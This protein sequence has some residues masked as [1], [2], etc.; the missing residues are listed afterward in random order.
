MNAARS[1]KMQQLQQP[2]DVI[3][4][5]GGITGAAIALEC[6]RGGLKTLLLEQRD[7]AWGTSSRSSKLVHGGLRYL[8]E[9]QFH[10][11]AESVKEREALKQE[12]RGLIDPQSF[13]L[14]HYPRRKPGRL[15]FKLGLTL[16]DAIAGKRAHRYINTSSAPFLAPHID[17]RQLQGGMQYWD[18]KTDDARLVM[19]V[20]EEAE[21]A[22]ALAIN[23]CC[24]ENLLK[25]GD[26]V[27]GIE[28][29][30]VE[31]DQRT[32]IRASVVVNATGAWVDQLRGQIG[33][34]QKIRPLRGSH[35]LFPLWKVPV[36]QS[37]SFFHPYDDRPVFIYP[38]EG[39]ALLGTTDVDHPDELNQEAV[40][41]PEE[42]AYLLAALHYQFPGLNIALSD[43]ISSYA[44]V[45]PVIGTGQIDPS[46]E[47]RDHLILNE[48]GLITV[49]GGKLTTFRP[50]AL[51]T[52][53]I[54]F[55]ALGKPQTPRWSPVFKTAEIT[56]WPFALPE[57]TRQRLSGR[58]GRVLESALRTA[59]RADFERIGGTDTL[60]LE[61]RMAAEDKSVVHLDDL[62][63]RR[64]R[65]GNVLKEG[66]KELLPVIQRYVQ[67]QLGWTSE[68]W[69]A[70]AQRYVAL[71][72]RNYSVPARIPP[73]E[74][75][76]HPKAK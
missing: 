76:L 69:Q 43:V 12:A 25:A 45:R 9:G 14:A 54:I 35:L 29:R 21:A 57:S 34:E 33:G 30:D 59:T 63:L 70:E 49:T 52:V 13:F 64:T 15:T 3:I 68:Q 27:V 7:F 39:V 65:L 31:T 44:G 2:F 24:V 62:L 66:G 37:V 71:W 50:I 61:L 67:P 47:S 38:W 1:A 75:Y 17:Q 4:V 74:P 26:Q 11:T 60:W 16:Y 58:F 40:I 8:K 10:L 55:Q 48:K 46:K 53:K 5:G 42:T 51:D 28:A 56:S 20:L 6:A 41:T 32:S 72:Q 19:R 36:A 73:L 22:G 23:Y 18:A